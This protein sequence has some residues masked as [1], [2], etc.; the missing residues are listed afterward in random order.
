MITR[1]DH[2]A[3]TSASGDHALVEATGLGAVVGLAA[4]F[5]PLPHLTPTL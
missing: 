3:S 2:K 5:L 4:E 1:A